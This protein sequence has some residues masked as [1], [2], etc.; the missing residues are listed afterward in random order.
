LVQA[1]PGAL[2]EDL[3]AKAVERVRLYSGARIT[4]QAIR[5]DP[6]LTFTGEPWKC[7]RKDDLLVLAP[8]PARSVPLGRDYIFDGP[9]DGKGLLQIGELRTVSRTLYVIVYR[10]EVYRLSRAAWTLKYSVVGRFPMRPMER[11]Q[12]QPAMREAA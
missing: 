5:F 3:Q 4:G 1:W 8:A 12:Q 11:A 10:G 9:A 7:Y 6:S 2:P